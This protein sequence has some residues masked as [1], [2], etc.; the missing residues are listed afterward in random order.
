[1]LLEVVNSRETLQSD[2]G[3]TTGYSI[4]KM[5]RGVWDVVRAQQRVIDD[6]E[7]RL[8]ALEGDADPNA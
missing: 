2:S 6:L 1:M 7:A 4:N 3:E 8:A 5:A